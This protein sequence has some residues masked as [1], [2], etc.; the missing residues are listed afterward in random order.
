MSVDY[1]D[2]VFL[3][4]TDFPMRAGLPKKEPETLQRWK[5]M[6]LYRVLRE[7]SAGREKFILH[8]GPPYAN[9]HLH[10]GHALN[11]ILKDI[12]NRGQQMMGKDAPY[13]P[14]WDCHG[15]PIEWKIEERYR[16]KGQDK[17][18]VPVIQ[19]REECREFAK[20][21]IGIQ[22]EEFARMGVEGDW[23]H[24]YTTMTHDAEAK[25]AEE[26]GKFLL[27]GQLYRGAKPVMWSVVEKTALAEAEIEYY[28][29]G[30][31]TIFVRFPVATATT[32]EI[33]GTS[34]VI[35]TT[36]PWTMPGNRA[37]AYGAEIDYVALRV[38]GVSGE[39]SLAKAGETII[40]AEAL[41]AEV[42]AAAGIGDHEIT[43]RFKGAAM[44]G[45]VL[46]HPLHAAGY[47]FDVPMLPAPFVEVDTGSGFVHIAP[48]H[49]QEDWELGM[50][51]GVPVPETVG[52]DGAFFD[53]V[54]LFAGLNVLEIKGPRK[55]DFPA[56]WAVL[57]EL[58]THGGL[59]AKG[60][61]VH[62]YPHSWRSK[63]P[64][65]YRNTPQWFIS[66]ESK[67][68]RKKALAAIAETRFVPNSGQ[69]R[70]HS[71]I[72]SRPDWCVSRQRAW[73]VPI[74][75]FVNKKTGEPLRDAAVMAR[76]VTAF[77]ED[78]ADAWYA[79]DP[80]EFLGNEHNAEDFEKIT[81]ILD[82]WFDS[83]STHAFV[84]ED[85]E[86]PELTWPASLYLE[87]TDQHRGWFHSSI[88]ECCGT[89]GVAPYEAVL[90][91]GFVMAE[92]G[93]KMSKSLGNIVSPQ[94]VVD[95]YGA[96]I[97][98]LWVVT[99]DYSDD[100]RIGP[101]IIK[102]LADVYRRLRNTLRYLLGNLNGFDPAERLPVDQMPELERWVLHRVWTLDKTIRK[103]CDD[104][105]YHHAFADLHT[106]CAVDLSAFY[107]DVRKDSLYCDAPADLSRRAT[108]TVLET[109]YDCLTAWLAPFL[110]FTAEEAWLT[111]NPGETESVHR[112][113]FP[114]I[115]EDWR[116]DALAAKWAKVRELRRV[117][118]GAL[119]VER[120]EK[121]IG[122]SLQA[123]PRVY[124]T[125]AH[126][127]ALSGL[128][129]AEIAITSGAVLETGTI[130][131]G[132]FTLDEVADIGVV[133]EKANGE[134]CERCW[135]VLEEVG[136]T[137]AH[138]TL[139]HRCAAAIG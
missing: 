105:V 31:T 60:K 102:Q 107:F 80:Q 79:R 42:C 83:G 89:R 27:D 64:L 124:A 35:W 1:K 19:F 59:L 20:H 39:K 134:K 48:G 111:R 84:L 52:P 68:L 76:I 126:V 137:A 104:F 90:T 23:N 101:E 66:M 22:R 94:D 58:N 9:G 56:N 75:V 21:W 108:R 15:L 40:I 139:C 117:V 71:M 28:D 74:T 13:V 29:H 30:S 38:D 16:E 2:T 121:R 57:R 127:E 110:C 116:D 123:A 51:F 109:L 36:T 45:S 32:P 97:L 41:V 63:A 4:K 113:V 72:A 44:E 129:L 132:A 33:D 46:R 86:W 119:E 82:V 131:E 120:A 136:E 5:D 12:I 26:L 17:D 125:A 50:Q 18:Q 8:D 118:T 103:A 106:F 128:D 14:G 53:H 7:D 81:D 25:I 11:K 138:P 115:P 91:H 61:L 10:I 62:S 65:I 69:K 73:G 47:D 78:G 6:D 112:R 100:L 85:G 88:L 3:P 54:P 70:L 98:R 87:G 37:V 49:G 96:D 133:V 135:R 95:Q 55:F 34:V 43:A 93:Q 130:P 99:S 24:P 122:S 77:K 92:D 67:D 114:N